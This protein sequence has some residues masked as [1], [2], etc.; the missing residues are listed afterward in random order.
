MV[1]ELR[2][3]RK[4]SAFIQAGLKEEARKVNSKSAPRPKL[5]LR[6]EARAPFLAQYWELKRNPVLQLGDAEIRRQIAKNMPGDGRPENKARTLLNW[7]H[8]EANSSGK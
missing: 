4:A 5:D 1:A 6:R 7:L 2:D 3:I 8:D